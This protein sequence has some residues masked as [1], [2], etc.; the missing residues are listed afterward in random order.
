VT[1]KHLETP[2]ISERCPRLQQS[3]GEIFRYVDADYS[4]AFLNGGSNRLASLGFYQAIELQ[5]IRG[6]A[7]EGFACMNYPTH[8]NDPSDP[9]PPPLPKESPVADLYYKADLIAGVKVEEV[10]A[11][12]LIFCLS[13]RCS[14]GL[15][16]AFGKPGK[17]AKCIHIVSLLDVVNS[18]HTA[19]CELYPATPEPWVNPVVYGSRSREF[20]LDP[21][22]VSPAFRK[23]YRDCYQCELR[24][25]WQPPQL[26]AN[27]Q[28]V[29]VKTQSLGEAAREVDPATRPIT[30]SIGQAAISD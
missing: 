13:T 17:P 3:V 10:V 1:I 19:V 21:L 11:P 4:N 27:L 6:D 15:A 22:P 20:T 12:T 14:T 26:P 7:E 16:R 30:S 2:P 9:R 24:V 23:H 18:L 5:D 29:F 28:H 25:A 8:A